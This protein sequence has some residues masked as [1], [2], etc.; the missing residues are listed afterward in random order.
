MGMTEIYE[1][2]DQQR[3]KEFRSSKR[4]VQMFEKSSQCGKRHLICSSGLKVFYRT[5]NKSNSC[6][7]SLS[8]SN[9]S[10]TA[11]KLSFEVKNGLFSSSSNI[12]THRDRLSVVKPGKNLYQNRFFETF[13]VLKYRDTSIVDRRGKNLYQNE[14][15]ETYH[16]QNPE[17]HKKEF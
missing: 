13:H 4:R 3:K 1:N 11:L 6:V 8:S 7:K 9:V 10:K 12:F 5:K 14:F 16:V 15:S 2:V 17:K